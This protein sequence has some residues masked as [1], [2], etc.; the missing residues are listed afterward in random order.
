MLDHDSGDILYFKDEPVYL[1]KYVTELHTPERWLKSRREVKFGEKPIKYVTGMYNDKTKLAELYGFWQTK[2]F[3]LK[4]TD[5]GHIP[6]SRYDTIEIFNGP[7]PPECSYVNV[8][9]SI[10]LSK[11][12]GIEYVPAVIGFDQG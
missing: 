10:F 9:K 12:L 5:D 11:K 7:L 8:A 1:R 3:Q 4:L 2:P 6:K